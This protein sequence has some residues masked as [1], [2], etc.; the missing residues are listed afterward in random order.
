MTKEEVIAFL[1]AIKHGLHQTG[2]D[3]PYRDDLIPKMKEALCIAI[4][5]LERLTPKKAG[6]SARL[7]NS[8]NW[9]WK[10]VGGYKCPECN[11]DVGYRNQ[12]C[13]QCGQALYWRT[14]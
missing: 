5:A 10:K 2:K 4:K 9:V 14:K 3:H 8:H 6:Y 1:G 12:F 11:A 7:V 13:P